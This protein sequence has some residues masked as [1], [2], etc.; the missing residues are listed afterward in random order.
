MSHVHRFLAPLKRT[1]IKSK[2][3]GRL[4][5]GS[6]VECGRVLK[7]KSQSICMRQDKLPDGSQ[8]QAYLHAARQCRS[9]DASEK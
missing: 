2:N 8:H 5:E 3:F 7:V 6:V 4:Q 9:A 1:L